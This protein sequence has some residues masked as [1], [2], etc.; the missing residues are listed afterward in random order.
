LAE[1]YHKR[2]F[3]A[4]ELADS[5]RALNEIKSGISAV[6]PDDPAS[7]QLYNRLANYYAD[8]GLPQGIIEAREAALKVAFNPGQQ[9]SQLDSLAGNY[10]RFG[11]I[12][13]AKAVLNRLDA[14]LSSARFRRQGALRQAMAAKAKAIFNYQLGYLAEAAS[15]SRKCVTYIRGHLGNSEDATDVHYFCVPTA[16]LTC[17]ESCCNRDS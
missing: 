6:G 5:G 13:Q 2:I 17:L 16:A 9:I 3:A 12:S 8:R 14:I 15:E 4:R 7:Y 1:H 11:D 10:L